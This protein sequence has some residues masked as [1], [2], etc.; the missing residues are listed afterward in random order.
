[1]PTAAFPTFATGSMRI[2]SSG[3]SGRRTA[4]T[5]TQKRTTPATYA[6]ALSTW[7]ARTQSSRLTAP[8]LRHLAERRDNEREWTPP[9]ATCGS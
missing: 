7:S 6:N 5:R 2:V 8:I 4:T 1:M 9:R 3:V